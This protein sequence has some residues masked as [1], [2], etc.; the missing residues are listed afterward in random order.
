M[1]SFDIESLLCARCCS[2]PYGTNDH[3]CGE[4]EGQ[5]NQETI[6]VKNI[7]IKNKYLSG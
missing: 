1:Y 3:V 7:M 6:C 4:E 2:C 5:I